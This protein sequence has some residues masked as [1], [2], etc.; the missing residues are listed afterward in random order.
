M[1]VGSLLFC[2][3]QDCFSRLGNCLCHVDTHTDI[4]IFYMHDITY[5]TE[6]IVEDIGD[7][8]VNKIRFL[9]LG[10]SGFLGQWVRGKEAH[11]SY[12]VKKAPKNGYGAPWSAEDR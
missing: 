6:G 11:G 3:Y 4:I 9:S 8:K 10:G 7:T 2:S 1:L 12:G 5:Y